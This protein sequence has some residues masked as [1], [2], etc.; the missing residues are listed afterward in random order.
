[1]IQICLSVILPQDYTQPHLNSTMKYR[2]IS[3]L[4]IK[5]HVCLQKLT[6]YVIIRFKYI[7]NGNET[8]FKPNE[9]YITL[10]NRSKAT[11]ELP[12]N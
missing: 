5:I 4:Y 3:K 7:F 11:V 1:M 8:L 10:N 6:I 12:T 9:E 2:I